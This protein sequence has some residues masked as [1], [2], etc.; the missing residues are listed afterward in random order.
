MLY[1]NNKKA[2]N[3]SPDA[4]F[5]TLED[6]NCEPRLKAVGHLGET[7][8]E[9]KGIFVTAFNHSDNDI[10]KNILME[11]GDGYPNCKILGIVVTVKG[12]FL[13][14]AEACKTSSDWAKWMQF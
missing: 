14:V 7:Q 3:L 5:Y 13:A 12:T 6:T 4:T 9:P 10:T 2:A 1:Y 8:N 11:L